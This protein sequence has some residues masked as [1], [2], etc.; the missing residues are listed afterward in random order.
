MCKGHKSSV[1]YFYLV[2]HPWVLKV[3]QEVFFGMYIKK[4]CNYKNYLYRT[5][6]SMSVTQGQMKEKLEGY[7]ISSTI[8]SKSDFSSSSISHEWFI[9]YV[10]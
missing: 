4:Y 8:F 7:I 6:S 2:D 9:I 10:I 5:Q 1:V 3:G